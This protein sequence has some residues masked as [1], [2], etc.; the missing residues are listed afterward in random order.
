[1]RFPTMHHC[2][3]THMLLSVKDR[4]GRMQSSD[5]GKVKHFGNVDQSLGTAI[6]ASLDLLTPTQHKLV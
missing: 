2:S 1:M 4:F 5:T 6:Q 3:E